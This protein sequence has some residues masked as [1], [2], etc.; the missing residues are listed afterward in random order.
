L[1]EGPQTDLRVYKNISPYV[2][3]CWKKKPTNYGGQITFVD[4]KIVS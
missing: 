4:K 3:G 1:D 2:G